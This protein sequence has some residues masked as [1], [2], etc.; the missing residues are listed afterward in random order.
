MSWLQVLGLVLRVA[1]A[2]ADIVRERKQMAAGEATATIKA[3]EESNARVE[4][5]RAARR[6][7]A[8]GGVSDDDPYLRD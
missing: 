6:A 1:M 2:I 5:A 8:A 3:L 7:A 4:K